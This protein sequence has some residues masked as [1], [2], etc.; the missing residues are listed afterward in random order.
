MVFRHIILLKLHSYVSHGA[1]A[2]ICSRTTHQEDKCPILAIPIVLS[3]MTYSVHRVRCLAD[4]SLVISA[5][6]C[7]SFPNA[8]HKF[9]KAIVRSWLLPSQVLYGDQSINQPIYLSIVISLY[10]SMCNAAV[11]S[12]RRIE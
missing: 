2:S 11:T 12:D 6:R 3:P 7:R 4:T 5:N 10:L 1:H 9:A 8:S